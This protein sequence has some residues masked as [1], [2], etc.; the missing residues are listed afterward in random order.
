MIDIEEGDDTHRCNA[1]AISFPNN[2]AL[3]KHME[4]EHQID[5]TKC[6]ETFKTQDDV[7]NH[8]NNCSRVIE[9]L[10]CEICNIELVSRA[11]LKRHTEKC[12]KKSSEDKEDFNEACTNGP[13]CRYLKENRCHYKHDKTNDQPWERVQHRR[14]GREHNKQQK[15]KQSPWRQSP[16]QQSPRQQSPRQQPPRR[17]PFR[18]QLQECQNGPGCIYWKHDRCNFSHPGS[19]Q[20]VD[21]RKQYLDSRQQRGGLDSRQQRRGL[22]SRQQRRGVDSRQQRQDSLDSSRQRQNEVTSQSRPCKFGASCDRIMTCGFLHHA[23]DFLSAQA[24]RRN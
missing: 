15:R 6:H 3:E 17:Q 11:G 24:G 16:R 21:S 18:Q 4:N 7:Y 22:D 12:Q 1:C 23:Q 19:R 10:M 2:N 20:G 14:Q 5:C 13:D 9:P 8:A